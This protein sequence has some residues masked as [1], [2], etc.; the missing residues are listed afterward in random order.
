M[1][2]RLKS[3]VWTVDEFLWGFLQSGRWRWQHSSAYVAAAITWLMFE[4]RKF[5]ETRVKLCYAIWRGLCGCNPIIPYVI[6]ATEFYGKMQVL[7]L[8]TKL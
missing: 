7:E 8:G 6:S 3:Q 2:A 5:S 4:G 1:E